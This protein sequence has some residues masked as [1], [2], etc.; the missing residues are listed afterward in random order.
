M[1][2]EE[3]RRNAT[4]CLVLASQVT[5][6]TNGVILIKMADLWTQLAELA[7]KNSKTDLVY[8]TPGT[9]PSA[10]PTKSVAQQQQQIQPKNR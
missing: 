6:R 1:S 9:T 10:E 7:E 4:A 5:D 2:V 8:E 3:Y